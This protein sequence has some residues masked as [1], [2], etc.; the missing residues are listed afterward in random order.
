MDKDHEEALEVEKM[1]SL[2]NG[3]NMTRDESSAKKLC[4]ELEIKNN[5]FAMAIKVYHGWNCDKDY[6]KSLKIFEEY[7]QQHRMDNF[8]EKG[9]EYKKMLMGYCCF[10]IGYSLTINY[11]F[12]ELFIIEKIPL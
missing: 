7:H 8:L 1:F 11:F 12:A 2:I 5:G 9:K 3:I 4:L 6:E 10:M